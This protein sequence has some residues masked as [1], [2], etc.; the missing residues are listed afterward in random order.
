MHHLL[1][2][3]ENVLK[4]Q[5]NITLNK[6]GW[7]ASNRAQKANAASMLDK[8]FMK[9]SAS[10]MHFVVH[11]VKLRFMFPFSNSLAQNSLKIYSSLSD[12]RRLK[13]Y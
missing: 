11:Q 3:Q 7:P 8:I 4:F 9:R 13:I 10:T 6:F 5:L 1:I 2:F 12:S